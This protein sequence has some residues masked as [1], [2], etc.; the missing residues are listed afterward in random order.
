MFWLGWLFC[1]NVLLMTV[2]IYGELTVAHS[3]L[4]AEVTDVSPENDGS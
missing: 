4:S 3:Q 2:S 1:Q